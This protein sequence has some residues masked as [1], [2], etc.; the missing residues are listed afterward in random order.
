MLPAQ[1]QEMIL[2]RI[3]AEG[4]VSNAELA[5]AFN[6]TH[7]TIRKDLEALAEAKRVIRI[8]GGAT[9]AS[10][11][12]HD[13]PLP[14]RQSVNQFEKSIVAQAAAALVGTNDTIFMDA[15]STVLAM[16]DNLPSVPLTVLT[17]AHHVIVALGGRPGYDLI[18]TGGNYEERSRSYV[19][20]VAEDSLKR[21]M[22]KW[23][24]V[25]VDG[26]HHEIGASEVN[27]GQ[28][29]LKERLIPRAEQ[30]CVVCDS[31]KLEKKSPFIFAQPRQLNVLV[32]DDRAAPGLLE[33]YR[34]QGI[35]VI[36]APLDRV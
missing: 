18:C 19:G 24:F 29:V 5:D 7:E 36:T 27:P 34:Q 31:S 17:N 11:S 21:Y 2:R 9:R 30:I 8:H 23:L 22:I 20:A 13:L 33:P 4:S 10:D 32:T 14:A 28:A 16:C 26:L 15:S 3:E 35:R 12:R 25:G 6:V 1:R